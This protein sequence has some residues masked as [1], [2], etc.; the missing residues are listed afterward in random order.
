MR[1]RSTLV[2]IL[3]LIGLG[4]YVYWVEVPKSQEEAKKKTIFEF[5][6]DDVTAVSLVYSDHEIVVKKSVR[7]GA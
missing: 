5:K 2:L 3:L 7:T 6:P 1:L 4:A